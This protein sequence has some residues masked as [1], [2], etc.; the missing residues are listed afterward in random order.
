MEKLKKIILQLDEEKYKFIESGFIKNHSN[1]FLLLFRYYREGNS[2]NLLEILNCNE[3]ALYVLKSRLYDKIQKNLL[4]FISEE[5]SSNE[6]LEINYLDNYLTLYPRD[7]AIAMLHEIE[8]QYLK[9]S[10]FLN[11]I[12]VYSVLKKA[13]YHSDKYYFYSQLY[14]KQV[15]YAVSFEKANDVLSNFNKTLA[16]FYFS[17][18]QENLEV[19]ILLKDEVK[20]I[21]FLNKSQ[22][23]E[24]ILNVI[25]IQ[26][27]LFANVEIPEEDPIEDLLQKSEEIINQSSEDSKISSFKLVIYFLKFEYYQHINQYKKSLYYFEIINENCNKWLLTNNY[28]LAF[29]FL[30]SKLLH[31]SKNHVNTTKHIN[32]MYHHDPYDF[33]SMVVLKFYLAVENYYAGNLKEAI[34][35]INKILDE[36]SF[37]NFAYMEFEIKLTLAYFY[38]RKHELELSENLLKNLSRKIGNPEYGKYNNVK[39]F[40]KL[41]NVMLDEKENKSYQTR[42]NALIEQY[43]YHNFS[44]RKILSFLQADLEALIQK[45]LP[46]KA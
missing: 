36:H 41:L 39:S 30:F 6:E 2:G 24:L 25:L 20:N 17:D 45:K 31:I 21:Y 15:A 37:V 13:Y 7:T 46:N 22:N 43:N 11:L 27:F 5:D 40:I 35:S 18:S 33:Y 38:Y 1:K 28:C 8:K 19:L 14:N 16:N 9:N 32:I 44:G 26:L 34:N 10:D 23:I 42:V 12:N 4:D 3:N 29:K